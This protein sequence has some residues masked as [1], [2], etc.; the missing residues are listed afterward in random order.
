METLAI[1]GAVGGG[2]GAALLLVRIGMGAV[3]ALMP[4]RR[5]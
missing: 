2:V 5:G 4:S 3:I 1:M